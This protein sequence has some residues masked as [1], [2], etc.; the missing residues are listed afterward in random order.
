[1][2]ENSNKEQALYMGL[3]PDWEEIHRQE[4]RLRDL[5]RILADPELKTPS[6]CL[7]CRFCTVIQDP[8]P[9]DDWNF[10][11]MAAYCS[12]LLKTEKEKLFDAEHPKYATSKIPFGFIVVGCRPHHLEDRLDV[13]PEVCPL[14]KK[15]R[16]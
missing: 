9:D 11:D 3:L 14:L 15:V 12:L 4:E 2:P 7:V 13:V 10:D 1:M 6:S 5:D 16:E 8:D